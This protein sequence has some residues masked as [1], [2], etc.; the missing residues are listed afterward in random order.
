MGRR[1]SSL[2]IEEK[3]EKQKQQKHKWY[4]KNKQ[5]VR[6]TTDIYRC[7]KIIEKYKDK[8]FRRRYKLVLFELKKVPCFKN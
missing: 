5:Q 8:I 2:T 6:D 7:K 3:F 1:K 4:L